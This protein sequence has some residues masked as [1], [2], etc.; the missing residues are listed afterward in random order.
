VNRPVVS[1]KSVAGPETW[2]HPARVT[3]GAVATGDGSLARGYTT[4]R[5]ATVCMFDASQ[6]GSGAWRV[7][8]ELRRASNIWQSRQLESRSVPADVSCQCRVLD[9]LGDD[10]APAY[11]AGH[12]DRIQSPID[13]SGAGWEAV[14][15]CPDL[16]SIW[17][18]DCPQSH[19]QGVKS[20]DVVC[21]GFRVIF[22]G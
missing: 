13:I 10:T 1:L 14:Y 12:L 2:R 4:I 7:V 18:M 15:R 9:E 16:G 19:L 11:T 20:P 3:G 22:D 8:E 5:D 6:L 21:D 17:L